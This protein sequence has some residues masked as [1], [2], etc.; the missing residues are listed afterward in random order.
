MIPAEA[1]APWGTDEP[2]FP[3]HRICELNKWLFQ[4][5][6]SRGNLLCRQSNGT[7]LEKRATQAWHRRVTSLQC[8]EYWAGKCKGL[9]AHWGGAITQL[10][11]RAASPMSFGGGQRKLL[12]GAIWEGRGQ[13]AHRSTGTEA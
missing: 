13:R 12:G 5:T 7:T 9:K 4:S 11:A 10:G 2:K 3:N 8:D 1:Q 6:K